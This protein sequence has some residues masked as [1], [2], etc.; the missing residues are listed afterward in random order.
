MIFFVILSALL[1]AVQS[2]QPVINSRKTT[3]TL[4]MSWPKTRPPVPNALFYKQKMDAAWGRGKFRYVAVIY[5]LYP[6]RYYA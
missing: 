1:L 4:H 3:T 2:F 6:T 5:L